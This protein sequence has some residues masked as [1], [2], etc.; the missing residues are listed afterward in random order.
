M[1]YF[2]LER[3]FLWATFSMS[4][5]CLL[6]DM[7][8]NTTCL[9]YLSHQPFS[10]SQPFS[11]LPLLWSHPSLN[12]LSPLLGKYLVPSAFFV[13][14]SYSLVGSFCELSLSRVSLLRLPSDA[15][16]PSSFERTCELHPLWAGS[17]W[18]SL[19]YTM[20]NERLYHTYRVYYLIVIYLYIYIYTYA[21]SC[22][23][24]L[25]LYNIYIFI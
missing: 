18:G 20:V 13:H 24:L 19:S 5:L 11:T 2:F 15:C 14:S 8:S 6:Q 17:G 23:V 16:T 22:I 9:S 12:Y 25:Q 21:L 10:C 4:Y 3:P 7:T 1:S